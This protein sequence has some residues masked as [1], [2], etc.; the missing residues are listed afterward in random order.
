ML[1][2]AE[3]VVVRPVRARAFGAARVR[4]PQRRTRRQGAPRAAEG[5]TACLWARIRGRPLGVAIRQQVPLLGRFIADFYAPARRLVIEVDGAYH[6]REHARTRVVMR[7]SSA[8]DSVCFASK[9][10]S[11]SAIS[12]ARSLRSAQRSS[13]LTRRP[14]GF[15]PLTYGSGVSGRVGVASVCELSE[16]LKLE[17][18]AES[19]ESTE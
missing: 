5:P 17:R 3:C 11:L 14:S 16:R 12:I 6:A 8:P 1:L 13:R 15:E 18:A 4:D 10:R 2:L 9:R 19:K 7:R